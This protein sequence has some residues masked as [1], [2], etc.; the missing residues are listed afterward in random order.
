MSV[1]PS[2]RLSDSM[3]TVVV[4]ISR[5][6]HYALV[7]FP[8]LLRI[9]V[10]CLVANEFLACDSRGRRECLAKSVA[11]VFCG[12][13]LSCVSGVAECIHISPQA[14]GLNAIEFGLWAESSELVCFGLVECLASESLASV[15]AKYALKCCNLGPA[16][17]SPAELVV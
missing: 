13:R 6:F 8:C 14:S 4:V 10:R 15:S 12:L 11:H 1:R 16:L 5:D 17:R 9:D 3:Q 7:L 2:V